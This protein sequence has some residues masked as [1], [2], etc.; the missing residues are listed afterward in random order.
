MRKLLAG[1]ALG[2]MV[3]SVSLSPVDAVNDFLVQAHA[4]YPIAG[5]RIDSCSLCHTSGAALNQ[6]GVDYAQ[7]NRNFVAIENTDSDLDGFSNIAEITALTFPGDASDKPA[8]GGRVQSRGTFDPGSAPFALAAATD[9]DRNEAFVVWGESAAVRGL[10]DLT[11][12]L[13]DDAGEAVGKAINFAAGRVN[14]EHGVSAAYAIKKKRFIASWTSDAETAEAQLFKS[15]KLKAFKKTISIADSGV[16]A[17]SDWAADQGRFLVASG[18]GAGVAINEVDTKGKVKRV[19]AR[20]HLIP[21]FDTVFGFAAGMLDS[22]RLLLAGA[23]AGKGFQP[24]TAL[25]ENGDATAIAT[26]VAK[27]TKGDTDM[28]AAIGADGLL[29]LQGTGKGQRLELGTDGSAVGKAG[30]LKGAKPGSLGVALQSDGNYLLVWVDSKKG[31]VLA[32]DTTADGKTTSKSF[33]IQADGEAAV[34]GLLAVVAMED[35]V[36]VV[37]VTEGDPGQVRT[38]V[39]GPQS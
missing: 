36:L 25:I 7:A 26:K 37:Y 18:T 28:A 27:S 1:L 39:V 10:G 30:K 9:V 33:E 16:G 24:G 34:P 38:A 15:K 3:L 35:A 4:Q 20:N 11:A 12:S 14:D 21:E 17:V 31:T 13:V 19:I 5:T 22:G 2:L 8:A 6:Y 32:V 23:S 29:V